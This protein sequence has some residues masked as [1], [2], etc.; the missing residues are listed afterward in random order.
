MSKQA[1]L[2][3]GAFA[4]LCLVACRPAGQP[5]LTKSCL[6][7]GAFQT[8]VHGIE[9]DL[10]VLANSNGLEACVTNYGARVVSLMVPDRGGNLVDVVLGHDSIAHYINVDGNFGAAIGRC[11]NRIAN[12]RFAIGP[13]TFQLPQNNFGHCLHGGDT[14]FHHAV[15][16]VVNKT[17]SSLTLHL[18][19][20]NG[21]AGFP[22]NLNVNLTYTL[23][24][25]NSLDIDYTA[26]TDAPTIVNLTN[27]S[28]FNLSGDHSSDILSEE[29]WINAPRYTPIDSTFMTTGAMDPVAGTPFDFNVPKPLG[30]DIGADDVQLRNGRGYDHNMVLASDRHITQ[31]AATLSDP[32]TGIAMDV[33]TTEPGIQLYTGNFLDGNVTGKH[34]VAYPHRGAICLETQHYP[35]S[36]NKPQ[37]PS[38]VL[39]PGETYKS[40]CSYRFKT[41]PQ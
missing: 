18:L 29:L 19:S 33:A 2:F 32:R 12:G 26:E 24:A 4:L 9:T 22:G 14:G 35:D 31:P 39:R 11:G 38:V 40:H 41:F 25:H 15:W 17:D 16:N 6:N 37:W 27:H 13:D 28:Y 34:G 20:P 1:K 5:H 10:Y 30:R 8:T 23:T 7:P 21:D 3:L 36:P